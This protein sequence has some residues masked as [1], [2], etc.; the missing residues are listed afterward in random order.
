MSD[1]P[2]TDEKDKSLKGNFAMCYGIMTEFSRQLE[3]ALAAKDADIVALKNE[4]ARLNGQTR[5]ACECGGTKVE[6]AAL[7]AQ[8]TTARACLELIATHGGTETDEGASCN[9]T[10]CA[11]QA[12]AAVANAP[13][14]RPL[15]VD[16]SGGGQ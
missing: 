15:V 10:W 14:H 4:V 16:N 6:V 13:A 9:G 12:R 2:R 1:T 3:R 8:L 5:Y 7:T 11:E